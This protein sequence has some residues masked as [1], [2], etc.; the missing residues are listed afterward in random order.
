MKIPVFRNTAT[1]YL[2]MAVRLAQGILV[3]RWLLASLGQEYYGLWA[4]LWS[5]FCYSLLLDFGF[6]VTAQK[7]TST[8]LYRRDIVRYNRTISTVFSFHAAMSA[9]ILLGTGV[10]AFFVPVLLHVE[11]SSPEELA[12]FRSCFLCFGIGSALVFP[13]GM[14]QEILVGLQ[15]LY[16]RNYINVVS[17]LVELAGIL[18]IFALGGGLITL[19]LFTV[20]LTALTQLSMLFFIRRLIP[21]FRLRF[22]VLPDPELFRKIFHFS[23]FVYLTSVA[24][25]AWGRSGALLISIFCGLGPT[26][27]YQ[28]GGRLPALMGQLTGPYQENISPITAL[29]HSR[30]KVRR[31]GLILRNSMR[32]N[33]FLA[34]GMTVGILFFSP[35]LL[36]FLF[37]VESPEAIAVCRIMTLSIYLSLVFR[38]IPERYF[39]MADSHRFLSWLVIGESVCFVILSIVFLPHYQEIAVVCCAFGVKLAGTCVLVVPRFLRRTGIGF[40]PLLCDTCLRQLGA[41]LPAAAAW[42]AELRLLEGRIPDFWLLAVAGGT[43][44]ILYPAASF[45]LVADEKER[46]KIFRKIRTYVNLVKIKGIR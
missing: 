20:I 2:I 39:L 3:T 5:F 17:K 14:F 37:R 21:G 25:L 29:L 44:A 42:Y 10:A 18:V 33:S 35:V 30:N 38:T 24:R 40:R 13:F 27:V 23:G 11:H 6:G 15:R 16:L 43:A 26:A 8:E 32:W 41:T 34:T 4:L 45:R 28:L 7:S 36:R 31:L 9:V 19:I 12:Y 22:R 46:G 1:N